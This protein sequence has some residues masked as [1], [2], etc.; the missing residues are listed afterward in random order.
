MNRIYTGALLLWFLGFAALLLSIT[1]K[2]VK[3]AGIEDKTAEAARSLESGSGELQALSQQI[4]QRGHELESFLD[5]INWVPQD[6]GFVR[7]QKVM[8]EEV[9]SL[10]RKVR[11]YIGQD[12]IYVVVDTR[13]NKLYLKKGLTLVFDADCSVGRGGI[14]RDAVTGRTWEFVTPLGEFKI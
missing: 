9:A 5:I 2:A 6:R 12:R 13:A 7:T 11:R 8:S 4:Q 3:I 1:D 10:R 14:L